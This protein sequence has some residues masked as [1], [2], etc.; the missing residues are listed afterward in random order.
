MIR[1]ADCKEHHILTEIS[2]A[3]KNY[4]NY[5]EEFLQIWQEE[6]TITKKYI[7][8]NEVVVIENGQ[9][10]LGYYSLAHLKSALHFSNFTIEAGHWMEHLFIQPSFIGKGLGKKLFEHC[11]KL[12]RSKNISKLKILADPNAKGFYLK[13]GCNYIKDCPSSIEGRTTPYLDYPVN[14]ASANYY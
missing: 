5:P 7:L 6:L 1:R 13:L 9:S 3:S 4:W 8:Q 10:I 2:F 14:I 11:L 12:C